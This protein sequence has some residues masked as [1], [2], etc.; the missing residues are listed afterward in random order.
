MG[1][2]K[3]GNE[4]NCANVAGIGQRGL[5]LFKERIL[6]IMDKTRIVYIFDM[7]ALNLT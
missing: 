1:G 3:N 7:A 6:E 4:W 5:L 2:E